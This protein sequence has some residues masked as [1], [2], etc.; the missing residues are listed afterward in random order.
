MTNKLSS[1]TFKKIYF[2][3]FFYKNKRNYIVHK[4]LAKTLDSIKSYKFTFRYKCDIIFF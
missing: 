3:T 1:L 4:N 2:F